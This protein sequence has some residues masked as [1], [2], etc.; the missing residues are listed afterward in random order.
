MKKMRQTGTCS[1]IFPAK[2]LYVLSLQNKVR[3]STINSNKLQVNE[4][5]LT[6][7]LV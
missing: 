4:N 1:L 2:K 6:S 7:V 5:K 3:I